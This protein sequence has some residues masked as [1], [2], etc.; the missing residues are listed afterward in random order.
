MSQLGTMYWILLKYYSLEFDCLHQIKAF[1]WHYIK[2]HSHLY[3]QSRKK[4]QLS[5]RWFRPAQ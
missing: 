4:A 5:N 2:I 3:K 1:N